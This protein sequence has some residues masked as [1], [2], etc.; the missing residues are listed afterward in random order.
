[1]R[2][3]KLAFTVGWLAAAAAAQAQEGSVVAAEAT[4][5]AGP[6]AAPPGSLPIFTVPPAAYPAAPPG[7][8]LAST[9]LDGI[10]RPWG[11][12]GPRAWVNAE[13]LLWW[14]TPMHSPGLMQTVP[15]AQALSAFGSSSPLPPGAAMQV[16]PGSSSVNFGAFSGARI[17][18]GMNFDGFGIDGSVFYLP[19]KTSSATLFNDGTPYSIAESYIR[20]GTGAPITLLASLAGQ[21][22]GGISSS[23]TSR[24]WGADANVRLPF[25][26]LFTDSTDALLGFRYLNLQDSLGVNF[27]SNLANG[28]AL[29]IQDAVE[30]HNNFYGG[31]VGL[32]GKI[33]GLERGLGLDFT[34]KLALGGVQQTALLSGSNTISVPGLPPSTMPGGLF[35]SGLNQGSYSR[36]KFAMLYEQ[37][38]NLTYNFN[39]WSQI[40][41]GYSIIWVSSVMRAGEAINPVVNDAILRF[42]A[43]APANNLPQQTFQW[44]AN[45]FWAQGITFGLRLQY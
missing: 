33:N 30:T 35:T 43:I 15:S 28:T 12:N 23:I 34:G 36:D 39:S 2:F 7:D 10:N 44:K 9:P 17:S 26:N 27:H 24:L 19:Q 20:A 8:P 1:M 41:I 21:A 6:P 16:F 22:T 32:N 5:P 40:Y 14:T 31:Q 4:A 3:A 37:N 38:I 42:V 13:Y 11:M 18:T 25:F 45:D 29:Q